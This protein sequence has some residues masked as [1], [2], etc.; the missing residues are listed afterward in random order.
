MQKNLESRL[1][2]KTKLHIRIYNTVGHPTSC[3]DYILEKKQSK[4]YSFIICHKRVYPTV[5]IVLCLA[6]LK[7][8]FNKQLSNIR[9]LNSI[10]ELDHEFTQFGVT[11]LEM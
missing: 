8:P 10:L 4:C 7:V 6:E 9:E 5:S 2:K 1:K 11:F 3:Y